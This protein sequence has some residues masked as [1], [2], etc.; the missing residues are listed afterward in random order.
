MRFSR[1]AFFIRVV[2]DFGSTKT[3]TTTSRSGSPPVSAH[4]FSN[5]APRAFSTA[6]ARSEAACYFVLISFSISV[7]E[8]RLLHRV[9]LQVTDGEVRINRSHVKSRGV[10]GMKEGRLTATS[11]SRIQPTQTFTSRGL[12]RATEP[13]GGT[14]V[15]SVPKSQAAALRASSQSA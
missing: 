14:S 12:T 5:G 15:C 8:V 6:S 9:P 10:Q 13:S 3:T 11:F 1:R 4:D 7:P 2:C